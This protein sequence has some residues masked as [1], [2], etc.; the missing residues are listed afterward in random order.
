MFRR[1]FVELGFKIQP[2]IQRWKGRFC[3]FKGLKACW[4]SGRFGLLGKS[5]NAHA[6]T[7]LDRDMDIHDVVLQ[8]PRSIKYN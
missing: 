6:G 1:P 5:I 8:I 2:L 7:N 4:S 3:D